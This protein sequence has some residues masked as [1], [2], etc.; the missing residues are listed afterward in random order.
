M[1]ANF[2]LFNSMPRYSVRYLDEKIISPSS[3]SMSFK[4]KIPLQHDFKIVEEERDE[5]KEVWEPVWG[6]NDKVR[7]EYKQL[8]LTLKE[9]ESP[10]RRIKIDLRAYD[11]ALG[12]KYSIPRQKKLD[13]FTIESEDT[14]FRFDDDF[15]CFALR[16]NSYSTN[17]EST[18]DRV[19]LTDINQDS[20]IG[21]P[22]LVET[23]KSWVA[24]TEANLTDYSGM[25]LS[26]E[27]NSPTTLV[28]SLSPLPNGSGKVNQTSPMST[29]W[30]ILLFGREPA[31]LVN[32]SDLI[33]NMNEPNK[34]ENS[35]WIRPGKVAWPWWSGRIVEN[36]GFEGGMNTST[37][38]YYADFASRSGLEYLLIDAG[39]YGDRIEGDVTEPIPGV[40]LESIVEYSAERDV[41]VLLW[42]HWRALDCR[43]EEAFSNYED[44][45]VS[46]I[47][48]DFM[49]RDDQEMV[50]FYR[51]VVEKAAKHHLTINFHG[52]YKPTGLRRTF[53]NLL[54][55]EGVLGLEHNK[56]N[57]EDSN[58]GREPTPKHNVTIPFTRMLA[59]PMDYTPGA[60]DLDGTEDSPKYVQTTRTQ[61]MAMYFV[62]FSP[63]QML[64]DY[65]SAYESSGE[66]FQ[67]I[68]SIPTTWDESKVLQGEPGKYIVVAR[69][70]DDEWYVGGM[71]GD[72]GREIEIPLAFLDE[73]KEYRAHIYS[74]SKGDSE[75]VEFDVKNVDFSSSIMAGMEEGGGLS[76]KLLPLK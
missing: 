24:V 13:N 7:N 75:K 30:R 62:Y 33:L 76:I 9:K 46:G 52:A 37:M 50:N 14:E 40:D 71:T 4:E 47:K 16:L 34:V 5:R 56:W 11:G 21:L 70:K 53:P 35:D 38:K 18:F 73:D 10:G 69:R 44:W 65:P 55:R 48:V 63:L 60:F 72:A 45:G 51:E 20:I 74:D 2:F 67:F 22:L 59:G 66:E 25:Y 15:K 3:L 39:W 57:K 49:D 68:K 64:P 26:G 31:D 58:V 43:I 12:F 6:E 41:D 28:S 19:C 36:E 17:Y 61:Q 1:E 8:N 23:R 42:V 27:E 54:T 29:P 32:S